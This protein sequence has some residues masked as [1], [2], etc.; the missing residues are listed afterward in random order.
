M[1]KVSIQFQSEG[2]A[3]VLADWANL[4]KAE[5][6]AAAEALNVGRA[7]DKAATGLGK[8]GKFGQIEF[9]KLAQ[10]ITGVSSA[11]DLT[12]KATGL[13]IQ[14]MRA[15]REERRQSEGLGQTAA[16]VEADLNQLAAGDASRKARLEAIREKIQ[17]ETG[18]DRTKAG[19]LTFT[20]ASTG[21]DSDADIQTLVDL[22]R[23]QGTG[24]D[25][26]EL[27]DAAASLR[28]ALGAGE[29]GSLREQLIKL[30]T[31]GNLSQKDPRAIA[32]QVIRAAPGASLQGI[33]DEQLQAAVAATI[34][35]LGE[36]TGSS[37]GAFTRFLASNKQFQGQDLSSSVASIQAKGL[38][39]PGLVKFLGSTEALAGFNAISKNIGEIERIQGQITANAAAA[40]TTNDLLA[41]ILST[42]SE[43][44]L[45]AEAREIARQQKEIAQVGT[46]APAELGTQTAVDAAT[47][48]EIG[49]GTAIATRL[50]RAPGRE[51]GELL[52]AGGAT[53]SVLAAGSQSL[54]TFSG[55]GLLVYQLEGL[56]RLG[57]RFLDDKPAAAPVTSGETP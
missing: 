18:V 26:R 47:A 25:A 37:I 38:D 7:A 52:G 24:G 1:A 51:L 22:Q 41:G 45:A 44:Q 32:Q 56:V 39:A 12:A 31:A 34:G 42:M 4:S 20:A 48:A 28:A 15:L 10:Q 53:Q 35:G 50:F 14:Q 29:V 27:V 54:F 21:F 5:Q 11:M 46:Q 17:R 6:K 19:G 16:Q 23:V 36:S 57:N 43:L 2:A 49:G 13:V 30:Q 8:A 55:I 33:S 9:G 3:K 40:G